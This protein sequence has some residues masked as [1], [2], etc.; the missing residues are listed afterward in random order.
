MNTTKAFIPR[1]RWARAAMVSAAMAASAAPVMADSLAATGVQGVVT[2]SPTCSG[3]QSEGAACSG[4]FSGA[5][6]S[7]Q[8]PEGNRV[9]TGTTPATGH[10]RLLAPAGDYRLLV[11]TPVKLMRCP[12]RGVHVP[13]TGFVSADIDCDSGMR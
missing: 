13:A 5:R 10:Y 9:A 12:A 11:R 2:L 8:S 6:V 4:P 3:A 7:L 1:S